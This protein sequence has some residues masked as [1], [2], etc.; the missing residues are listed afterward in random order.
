MATGNLENYG[1]KPRA[2]E[3][4]ALTDDTEKT[5]SCKVSPEIWARWRR[6]QQRLTPYGEI[7][8]TGVVRSSFLSALSDLER[9]ADELERPDGNGNAGKGGKAK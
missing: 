1:F 3:D 8:L 5:V 4:A 2:A 9:N 7:T 6:V